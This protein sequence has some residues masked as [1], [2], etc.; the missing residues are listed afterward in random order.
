M[1]TVPRILHIERK[2]ADQKVS[3]AEM[4]KT[5]RYR[6]KIKATHP[7]LY[8]LWLEWRGLLVYEQLKSE[9]EIP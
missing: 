3:A 9:G 8:D 2:L 1:T 4:T 5:L 6:K 7:E